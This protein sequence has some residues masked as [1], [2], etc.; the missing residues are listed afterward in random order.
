MS[1]FLKNDRLKR[2][3]S[4]VFLNIKGYETDDYFGDGQENTL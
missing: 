2:F 1:Q 3:E 4:I